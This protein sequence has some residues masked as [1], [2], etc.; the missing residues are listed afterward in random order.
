MKARDVMTSPVITVPAS[1]SVKDVAKVLLQNHISAVP[2]VDDRGEL[3]GIVSEGD[4][5]RR[6]ETGTERHPRRW[7]VL[8][9]EQQLATEYVKAHAT[10]VAD[11]MTR[12][13]VTADPDTPLNEIATLLERNSIKRVPIMHNGQLVGIVS[14]ANLIQ[15]LAADRTASDLP[16]A[17]G[18]IRDRLLSHLKAQPWAHPALL[19]ITVRDGIVD[20]WGVASSE[21]EK[22]A[23]RVAAENTAG[24]RAI[25]DNLI[26]RFWQQE[27]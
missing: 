4:L 24:V 8:F 11:I 19:N 25:N 22:R 1:A 5:M 15:A 10:R 20:L 18:M 2:V 17:D 13:V 3:V 7:L 16:I 27:M 23:I 12:Y 6:P 9:S 21:E 14:R 26:K